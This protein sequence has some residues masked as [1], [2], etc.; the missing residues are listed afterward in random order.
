MTEESNS[1]AVVAVYDIIET[2]DGQ[3]MPSRGAGWFEGTIHLGP[4]LFSGGSIEFLKNVIIFYI[5]AAITNDVGMR[6]EDVQQSLRV[7]HDFDRL[8]ILAPTMP[9][10]IGVN[11]RTRFTSSL[12]LDPPQD[13]PPQQSPPHGSAASN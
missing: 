12:P 11:Y 8:E 2:E 4:A 5:H 1:N 7:S 3:V 10:C 6:L 13:E 9:Y